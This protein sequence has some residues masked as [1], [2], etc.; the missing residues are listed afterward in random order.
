MKRRRRKYLQMTVVWW[1]RHAHVKLAKRG[2]S[3]KSSIGRQLSPTRP[4]LRVPECRPFPALAPAHHAKTLA[5][6]KTTP[7]SPTPMTGKRRSPGQ[8][9]NVARRALKARKRSEMSISYHFYSRLPTRTNGAREK[10]SP[11][12]RYE[13]G[14]LSPP[15]MARRLPASFSLASKSLRIMP[16]AILSV[17]PKLPETLVASL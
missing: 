11:F 12:R 6:P 8:L 10:S 13:L 15:Y 17:Y 16:L 5:K 3:W 7:S 9:Q 4:P 1:R 14:F 2:C